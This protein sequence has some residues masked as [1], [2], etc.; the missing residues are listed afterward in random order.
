[1]DLILCILGILI[2]Y[3]LQLHLIETI[4][5]NQ[6]KAMKNP[7]Y[8]PPGKIFNND[9]DCFYNFF[10]TIYWAIAFILTIIYVFV[11]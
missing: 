10:W 4:I 1:M 5:G 11:I 7:Y 3:D 2:L 8:W 9:S 6:Q